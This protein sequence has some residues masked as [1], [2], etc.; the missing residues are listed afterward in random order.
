MYERTLAPNRMHLQMWC[1]ANS[2]DAQA[3][4][5][6]GEHIPQYALQRKRLEE[7]PDGNERRPARSLQCIDPQT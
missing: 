7:K 4:S 5:L 3:G 2:S 6:A 1:L